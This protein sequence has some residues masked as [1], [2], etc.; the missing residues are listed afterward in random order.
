[1]KTNQRYTTSM[2]MN[3]LRFYQLPM[4]LF[5]N[6]KYEKLSNDARVLYGILKQRFELSIKN[7]WVNDNEEIYFVF[8]V[9]HL[10]DLLHISKPT[11]I[12][13]KQ[14]LTE[15]GLLE[16][17]RTGRANRMY[18]LMPHATAEDIRQ[19]HKTTT[20]EPTIDYSILEREDNGQIAES[21][22]KYTEN[23]EFLHQAETQS[24]QQLHQKSNNLESEVKEIVPSYKDL[25]K[26]KQGEAN[27][28]KRAC[29]KSEKYELAP[30]VAEVLDESGLFDECDK[31]RVALSFK[32][33]AKEH[34]F[35]NIDMVIERVNHMKTKVQV[36]HET[37]YNT[38]AYF[39]HG[40]RE[41]AKQHLVALQAEPIPEIHFHDWLNG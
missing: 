3:E 19:S 16:E 31:D 6:P 30:A 20:I 26:Q 9:K 33:F 14:Q 13:A 1:M 7:N 29:E 22:V 18:L 25:N 2:V 11:A 32:L 23:Q 41:L 36:C 12:K 8:P 15:A 5:T 24:N 40:I 34:T 17:E 10:A 37:I 39:I 4:V 35:V 38:P 21:T 28:N 27:N